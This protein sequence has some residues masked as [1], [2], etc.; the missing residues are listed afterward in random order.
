[1]TDVQPTESLA[2]VAYAA[3]DLLPASQRSV[4]WL[5]C[6]ALLDKWCIA[7]D[8]HDLG[9]RTPDT[10]LLEIVSPAKAVE[11]LSLP[12]VVKRRVSS[13]GLGVE[14]FE[15]LESLEDFV[16]R[17]E[18]PREWIFQ[19]FVEGRSLVCASCAGDDGFELIATYEILKR[20]YARG[21]SIV[22]GIVRDESVTKTLSDL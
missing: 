11:K 9:L 10:L 6:P 4:T 3:L 13:G 14:I 19:R 16:S 8:L 7:S 1:M 21:P 20:S 22:V 18:G 15:C 5:G 12:I 2:I 17:I